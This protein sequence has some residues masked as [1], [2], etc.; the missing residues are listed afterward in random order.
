MREMEQV[1]EPAFARDRPDLIRTVRA[2]ADRLLSS[3]ESQ[4]PLELAS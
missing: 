4:A 1:G 3:L 2:A